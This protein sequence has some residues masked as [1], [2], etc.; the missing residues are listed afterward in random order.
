MIVNPS[1]PEPTRRR[2][3]TAEAAAEGRMLRHEDWMTRA[4]IAE[5]TAWRKRSLKEMRV[6]RER[7][8]AAKDRAL[9]TWTTGSLSS[10]LTDLEG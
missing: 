7:E 2:I 1:I 10:Y 5:M 8:R 6:A 4:E 3:A 9:H